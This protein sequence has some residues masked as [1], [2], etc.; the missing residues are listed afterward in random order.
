MAS[1]LKKRYIQREEI[2][3]IIRNAESSCQYDANK[4]TSNTEEMA[5][6]QKTREKSSQSSKD[7]PL[8]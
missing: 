4:L 1:Q 7:V 6:K 8:V 5:N 2:N 3:E